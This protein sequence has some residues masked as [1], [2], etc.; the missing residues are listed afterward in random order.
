M[1]AGG[2]ALGGPPRVQL[3]GTGTGAL[4]SRVRAARTGCAPLAGS[5]N[6]SEPQLTMGT[7]RPAS[8]RL[9]RSGQGQQCPRTA[10]SRRPQ[11]P[12]PSPQGVTWDR[13]V[14]RKRGRSLTSPK[15]PFPSTRYCLNVFLVT[16]C[17]EKSKNP[18]LVSR[19]QGAESIGG[20][21][22]LHR[23]RRRSSA[24]R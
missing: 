12:P 5:P 3:R 20:R 17:L 14:N 8:S 7:T 21:R 1:L 15:P 13:T 18:G 19:R 4:G 24:S 23:T 2:S 22:R 11:P 6:H 10:T 16:G 9:G